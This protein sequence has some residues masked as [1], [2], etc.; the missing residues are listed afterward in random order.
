MNGHIAWFV[1]GRAPIR[2]NWDGLLPVPGDG[3]YEWAGFHPQSVLPASVD[4]ASGYLA[5]ANELNLPPDHDIEQTR[6]GFEWAEPSRGQRLQEVLRDSTAHSVADSQALQTDVLS[7]PA[8]RLCALIGVGFG[9][10]HFLK[11]SIGSGRSDILTNRT[12]KQEIFL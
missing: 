12:A 11:G 8:R 6:L 9:G 7:I 2:S 3:R 10:N 1:A 4:P 5:T